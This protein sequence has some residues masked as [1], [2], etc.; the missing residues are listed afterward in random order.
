LGLKEE[1]ARKWRSLYN[2]KLHD[3]YFSPD[4]DRVMKSRRLRWA[5]HVARMGEMKNAYEILVG[6]P[7]GKEPL[8]RPRFR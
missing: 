2:E 6:K 5:V 4:I 1:V 7:E 8:E 3:L